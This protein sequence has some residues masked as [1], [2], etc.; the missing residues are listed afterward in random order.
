MKITGT[1]TV[2]RSSFTAS[3]PELPSASW[4]SARIS[5][6]R[7]FFASA[8]ASAWVR[9]MPITLWPRLSTKRLDVHGNERLV[10]DDEDIG[11]DFG[12]EFAAGLFD[13]AA[14]RRQVAVEHFGRVLLGKSFE[15]HQQEGLPGPRRD[16]GQV[17]LRRQDRSAASDL[18]FTAT[19]LQILVNSRYRAT[20]ELELALKNLRAGDQRLEG[21]GHIGV[22]RGLATGKRPS[23]AAQKWQLLQYGL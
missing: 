10:L 17:L 1:S 19:E 9:A 15:R 11:G 8:S 2:P 12:G 22:A 13:Q 20:R 3:S 16:L 21:C 5:P 14:Q 18:S 7:F 4:M 6:G 23:V